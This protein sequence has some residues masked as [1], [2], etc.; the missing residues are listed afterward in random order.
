[1]PPRRPA[2]PRLRDFARAAVALLGFW[3]GAM[4]QEADGRVAAERLLYA[5]AKQWVQTKDPEVR[6]EA[7][8]VLAASGDDH[9]YP[10]VLAVAE[11]EPEAA[12]LRGILAL[13]YLATPGTAAGLER[14]LEHEAGRAT[15][16]A[17]C[18]AF[19]LASLPGSQGDAAINQLLSRLSEG[20]WKRQGDLLLAV[21]AALVD[22]GAEEQRAVLQ[23]L[24]DDASLREPVLRAAVLTT[25]A[26]IPGATTD[27]QLHTAL[28]SP[29]SDLR[30]AA[31]VALAAREDLEAHWLEVA[32]RLAQRDESPR[33]RARA[34]LVLTTARHL[35]ALDLA[36][37]ALRSDDAALVAQA[38]R[39]GQH[40]GGE[41]MRRTLE[42]QFPH[43]AAVGQVALLDEL[44]TPVSDEFAVECRAVVADGKYDEGV[45][46]SA[47]LLLAR[48]GETGLQDQLAAAFARATDPRTHLVLARAYGRAVDGDPKALLDAVAVDSAAAVGRLTALLRAGSAGASRFCIERLRRTDLP[49]GPGAVLR[50]LRGSRLPQ[51]G[52]TARE[53]APEPV[54]SLLGRDG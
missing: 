41:P 3:T 6:G 24:F 14:L 12:R 37:K 46:T 15:P 25:L 13:G 40:L 33:V 34:L 9:A 44:A 10:L 39:T 50:A 48:N 52:E 49:P 54:R 43:L 29:S 8:L 1:M 5:D 32:T 51:L 45:R 21:L 36:A 26:R 31:L 23:R 28:A 16:T 38:V 19:A 11:A 2:A 18:A 53:L 4:A 47:L 27:K 42:R 7:A 20:S 35:P 30:A 22:R 17:V